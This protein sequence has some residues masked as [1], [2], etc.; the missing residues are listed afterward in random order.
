MT[1][2]KTIFEMKRASVDGS[3]SAKIILE[4]GKS[5]KIGK[6]LV[7]ITYNTPVA[8]YEFKKHRLYLL[9]TK[10]DY[11]NVLKWHLQAFI[12]EFVSAPW[13]SMKDVYTDARTSK[14][15]LSI[16]QKCRTKINIKLR[17]I[18]CI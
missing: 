3:P 15:I 1:S 6:S 16:C 14:K 18:E 13:C 17:G 9:H 12:K 4:N 7:L 2:N 11:T 5:V 8:L 10:Y